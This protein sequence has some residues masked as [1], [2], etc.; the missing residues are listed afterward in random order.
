MFLLDFD[1]ADFFLEGVFLLDFDWVAF[2]LDEGFFFTVLGGDFFLTA[3]E[4]GFLF[5]FFTCG[6]CDN[7]FCPFL[8]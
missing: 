1:W 5:G 6:L 2:F 7:F 4:E 3:L 8:L